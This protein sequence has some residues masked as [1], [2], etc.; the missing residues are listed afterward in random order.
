MLSLPTTLLFLFLSSSLA[1]AGDM[2]EGN[3]CSV[4]NNKLQIGTYEFS[5]DCNVFT[6][7]NPKTSKCEKKGCRRDEFPFGYT[8]GVELPPRC[9]EG[10][11]CPDEQDSC[12]A[13]LPVGS[14]CQLNRDD[15]C[16]PPPNAKELADKSP[17]GLN[18]NGAVCLNF[19]CMWANVT[20][21]LP[22]VV[23]N[24][25]YISYGAN[26]EYIDIMCQL[27]CSDNCRVGHYC[28]AT[29]KV[30]IQQKNIGAQCTADKECL[31]YNCGISGKC[32]K[33]VRAPNS[34]P[35]WVY[36]VVGIG[37]FGGMF[38]TLFGLFYFHGK[39]REVE[40]EKRMQY[41]REQTAF[42]QNIL[43]IRD[44]A[45]LT[46][47]SVSARGSVLHHRDRDGSSDDS[48]APILQYSSKSSHLRQTTS[49]DRDDTSSI[50]HMSQPQ[51]QTLY[52][53]GRF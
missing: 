51:P 18:F 2:K 37:I 3:P 9:P 46:Q 17:H 36:V 10:Q 50:L 21:G 1:N 34:L 47:G 33:D 6:S 40:R 43:Q 49:D 28:D 35:I 19:K 27:L 16:Q 26:D 31:S 41:W 25:A 14:D 8:R 11:F 4:D 39:Q 52:K 29:Q 5:S 12:Q 38:A 7:C 53:G 23:E 30:C 45:I 15:Q 13:R 48:H 20:L 22:C 24:T 44:T 42:R 32:D